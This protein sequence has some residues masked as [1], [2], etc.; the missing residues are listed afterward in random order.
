M[1][2]RDMSLKGSIKVSLPSARGKLFS[3]N[4]SAVGA[5]EDGSASSDWGGAG[6]F[7]LAPPPPTR[8]TP[9]A[10]GNTDDGTAAN[11]M[12]AATASSGASGAGNVPIMA[13]RVPGGASVE[14]AVDGG[15]AAAQQ[16]AAAFDYDDDDFGDFVG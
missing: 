9:L 5:A 7:R 13:A 12:P 11:S 4:A 6:D 2:A 3:A 14:P 8:R 15:A 1:A 16:G 10:R